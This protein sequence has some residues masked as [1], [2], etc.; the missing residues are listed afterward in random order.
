[1]ADERDDRDARRLKMTRAF[2]S[3]VP[4]S[5]AL[6]IRIIDI[7]DTEVLY[8]LPVRRQAGRE[9]RHRDASRRRDHN[10][11]RRLFRGGGVCGADRACPDR[12]PRSA[13]RLPAAGG[14]GQVGDRQGHAATRSRATWRSPVRSHIRT[15]RRTRSHT[16]SAPSCC[17]PSWGSRDRTSGAGSD[18]DIDRPDDRGEGVA[19]LSGPDRSGAVREVPRASRRGC[20]VTS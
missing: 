5:Q 20:T 4:H 12:D 10:A 16:R 1:M 6:G 9:P 3:V 13:D 14:A 7:T 8:E 15:I 19:G 11:T 18:A 17:R 2:V